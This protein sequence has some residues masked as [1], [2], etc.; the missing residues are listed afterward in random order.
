MCAR[1]VRCVCARYVRGVCA[2]TRTERLFEA[3]EGEN[4]GELYG[5]PNLM[6]FDEGGFLQ[7]MRANEGSSR[8]DNNPAQASAAN[9]GTGDALADSLAES[10]YRPLRP[11]ACLARLSHLL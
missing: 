6:R 11:V 8:P 3:I 7:R 10:L 4:K 2:G 9:G 5:L 1:C